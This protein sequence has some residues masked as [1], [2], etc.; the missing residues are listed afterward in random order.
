MK[1]VKFQNKISKLGT[2]Y[3]IIINKSY[4]IKIKTWIN[5]PGCDLKEPQ[6]V[7]KRKKNISTFNLV[8]AAQSCDFTCI[9]QI[10]P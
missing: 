5:R 7:G 1:Y 4:K 9:L 8:R 2:I 10:F 6:W 3:I